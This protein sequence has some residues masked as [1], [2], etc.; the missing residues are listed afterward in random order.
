MFSA[1]PLLWQHTVADSVCEAEYIAA[2]DAAKEAVWLR[3]FITEL[4]VAPS[5]VGPV[6]L[7][8]DSSGAIA[9]TKEP[10]A[11]QRT[12][13]ILHRYHLIWEIVDRGDVDLQKI[14]GKGNLTDPF[15]KAIAVK[16][17]NDYKLKMGIRYCTDRL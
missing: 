17:F 5:L 4:G 8:C 12:K 9:Q 3:K 10:K 15:T 7:Y 13:H 14:D 16:E 6:L 2:S 1:T 11:H